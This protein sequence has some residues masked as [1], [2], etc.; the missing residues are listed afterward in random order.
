MPFHHA[1]RSFR[2]GERDG[3]R[4]P[5]EEVAA[6][7][8]VRSRAMFFRGNASTGQGTLNGGAPPHPDPLPQKGGVGGKSKWNA[9]SAAFSGERGLGK[10]PPSLWSKQMKRFDVDKTFS[11]AHPIPLP[12]PVRGNVAQ[13]GGVVRANGLGAGGRLVFGGRAAL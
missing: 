5:T 3:V 12:Q 10:A 8:V 7:C 4:G 1:L 9:A 11:S 2:M 13:N 6:R